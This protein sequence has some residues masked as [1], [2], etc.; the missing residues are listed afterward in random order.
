M[1]PANA[2]LARLGG[3]EFA[4]CIADLGPA[5]TTAEQLVANLRLHTPGTSIGMASHSG[6]GAEIAALLAAADAN[7]YATR[8]HRP[9]ITRDPDLGHAV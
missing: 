3:D 9:T 6:Y 2:V 4:L 8:Q 1:L 7:L 5:P